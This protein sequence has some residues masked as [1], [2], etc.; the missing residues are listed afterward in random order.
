[1]LPMKIIPGKIQKAGARYIYFIPSIYWM[2]TRTTTFII[3]AT[4]VMILTMIYTDLKPVNSPAVPDGGTSR[5]Y[6]LPLL[7]RLLTFK[8][9]TML[10]SIYNDS[11]RTN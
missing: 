10:Q 8:Q 9:Y 4:I 3:Q 11:F 6:D 5:R 7:Y 2:V 1:M